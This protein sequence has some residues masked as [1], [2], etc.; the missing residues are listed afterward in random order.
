MATRLSVAIAALIAIGLTSAGLA[1]GESDA[2]RLL[3]AAD[4]MAT[5]EAGIASPPH[6]SCLAWR[7]PDTTG[8][9]TGRASG[10]TYRLST[11]RTTSLALAFPS[12]RLRTGPSEVQNAGSILAAGSE[13][14]EIAYP[15]RHGRP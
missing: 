3:E 6:V 14:Q 2:A 11:P 8:S 7:R 1:G 4:P 13:H 9:F 10:A 12:L 5:H 15:R